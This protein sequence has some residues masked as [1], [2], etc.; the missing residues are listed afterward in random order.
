MTPIFNKN[1][2]EDYRSTGT[3]ILPWLGSGPGLNF[4]SSRAGLETFVQPQPK[5][6]NRPGFAGA[7]NPGRSI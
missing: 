3:E 7:G 4:V 1:L 5:V 6:K 2:I